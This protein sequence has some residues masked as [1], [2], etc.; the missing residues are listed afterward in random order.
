MSRRRV[1]MMLFGSGIPNLLATLQARAAYYENQT[2][3][4]AILDKI[5]KIQ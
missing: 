4:T 3:T 1:M 5:E 2:S